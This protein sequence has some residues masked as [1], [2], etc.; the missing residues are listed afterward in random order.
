MWPRELKRRSRPR[1]LP[2]RKRSKAQSKPPARKNPAIPVAIP[3][4]S[5]WKTCWAAGLARRPH[6][7]KLPPRLRKSSIKRIKA[8]VGR[9]LL[10]VGQSG[11]SG[12]AAE[13]ENEL[14][15]ARA[16]SQRRGSKFIRSRNDQQRIYEHKY[17]EYFRR[18]G[19]RAPRK[20]RSADDGLQAGPDRG[21]GRL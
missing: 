17:S 1:P 12:S 19:K 14:S 15:Q 4:I 21:Q 5:A 16:G 10:V 11:Y 7:P 20:D 8:V 3:K 18:T 6:P 9:W 2:P 13:R